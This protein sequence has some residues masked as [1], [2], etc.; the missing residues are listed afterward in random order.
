MVMAS[1][2][3]EDSGVGLELRLRRQVEKALISINN[4][5]AKNICCISKGE[6]NVRRGRSRD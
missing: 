4:P 5:E 3:D 6:V 1:A 2:T